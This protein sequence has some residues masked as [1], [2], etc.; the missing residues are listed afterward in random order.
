MKSRYQRLSQQQEKRVEKE[1]GARRQKASGA[2]LFAKGDNRLLGEL[3]VEAKVTTAKSFTLKVSDIEKIRS[4][5]YSGG[6]EDWVLQIDFNRPGGVNR[7]VA[8][9]DWY[10]YLEFL[11][12]KRGK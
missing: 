9:I 11:E 4:E 7:R 1:T 6:L 12:L 8:V 5:A 3:R 2:T 10:D